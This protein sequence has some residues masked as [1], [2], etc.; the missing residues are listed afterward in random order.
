[1]AHELRSVRPAVISPKTATELDELRK[2]RHLVRNVYTTHLDSKRMSALVTALA[3]LWNQLKVELNTFADF[4]NQL[5][6]A[7]ESD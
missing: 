4:V 6:H 2:F 1:M 7:D 3:P 5:S